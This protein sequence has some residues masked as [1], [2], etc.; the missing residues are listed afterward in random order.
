MNSK[1]PKIHYL[2]YRIRN[3]LNGHIYVGIHRTTNKKDSYMGSGPEIQAAIASF[4][5]ENFERRIIKVCKDENEM[6]DYEAKIV[7]REFL[8]RP[9]VM[10]K[11]LGGRGS[12]FSA[13]NRYTTN[14]GFARLAKENP[15]RHRELCR[16]GYERGIG[17]NV[18][19][20]NF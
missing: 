8:A 20:S 19:A 9:D 17:K 10:N 7:T 1:Q 4:G 18:C 2:V 6:F 11:N 13:N 14:R 5:I 15:E 12:F 16:R 3:K